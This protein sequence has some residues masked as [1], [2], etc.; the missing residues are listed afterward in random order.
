MHGRSIFRCRCR[1]TDWLTRANADG[2]LNHLSHVDNLRLKLRVFPSLA[3]DSVPWHPSVGLLCERGICK[4]REP[5]FKSK[6]PS[7][8]VLRMNSLPSATIGAVQLCPP[9]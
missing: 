8:F 5:H 9:S 6:H 3:R 1:G 4:I 2:A 7:F